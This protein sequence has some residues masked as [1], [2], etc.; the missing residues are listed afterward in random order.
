M[1]LNIKIILSI[2]NVK[3][4]VL[5]IQSIFFII[6]YAKLIGITLINIKFKTEV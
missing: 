4:V 1:M 3:L 2:Y 5:S 6:I